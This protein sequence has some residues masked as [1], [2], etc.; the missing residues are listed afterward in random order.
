[1]YP[2]KRSIM[3]VA[4]V[5]L[6]C[7][8]FSVPKTL[9]QTASLNVETP[10]ET[11]NIDEELTVNITISDMPSPGVIGYELELHFDTTYLEAVSAGMPSG[12]FLEPEN[13]TKIF[14]V[15]AGDINNTEGIVEF[16]AQ[17]LPPEFPP[18]KT[19]SGIIGTVTFRGKAEGLASVTIQDVILVDPDANP[20][21]EANYDINDGEITV[22]P[23]FS[24]VAMM[25]LLLA[26]TSVVLF[27]KKKAPLV[28]KM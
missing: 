26:A 5:L 2:T 14:I 22:I 8:Y 17:L 6:M 18:G 20:I 28:T 13:P 21:P 9:A 4:V 24:A 16:A 25:L 1:M 10:S 23:E 15:R 12:H 3:A 7:I 19:G 27:L 11:I